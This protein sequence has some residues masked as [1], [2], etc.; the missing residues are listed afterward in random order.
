MDSFIAGL[1]TG[2][3]LFW[4]CSFVAFS[5]PTRQ[6]GECYGFMLSVNPSVMCISIRGP[7]LTKCPCVYFQMMTR[8]NVNGF[9]TNMLYALILWRSGLGLL[10]G[11]FVNFW[12]GLFPCHTSVFSFQ[13]DNL[14]IFLWIFTKLYMYRYCR[15]LFW[16]CL[17]ANFISFWQSCLP[18]TRYHHHHHQQIFD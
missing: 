1:M 6:C 10:M 2:V 7:E 17:W 15:G 16:D 3:S 5:P 13:D 11:K 8:V 9:S 14:S 4:M 18:I 12:Q